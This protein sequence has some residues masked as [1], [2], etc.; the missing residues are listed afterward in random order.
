ME[1]RELQGKKEYYYRGREED[2]THEKL[3]LT[4]ETEQER[5][6]NPLETDTRNK[7]KKVE[8]EE[9]KAIEG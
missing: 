3:L 7:Q 5:K 8:K 2:N 4:L 1:R 9:K 6:R